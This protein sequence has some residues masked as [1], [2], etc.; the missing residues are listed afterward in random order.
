MQIAMTLGLRVLEIPVEVNH[1]TMICQ[2]LYFAK[3]ERVFICPSRLEINSEGVAYSP[4]S[5]EYSGSMSWGLYDDVEQVQGEL[6]SGR[7]DTKGWNLD[8]LSIAKLQKIKS[9]LES[10]ATKK[11]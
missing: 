8:N 1:Y 6:N 7:D 9:K 10:L 3:Q 5:H 2:A 4:P 11:V